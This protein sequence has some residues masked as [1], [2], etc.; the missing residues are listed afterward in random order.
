MDF[1][2]ITLEEKKTYLD[3]TAIEHRQPITDIIKH[4]GFD[5]YNKDNFKETPDYVNDLTEE[6]YVSGTEKFKFYKYKD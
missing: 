1:T 6:V 2:V 4:S 3:D 5:A